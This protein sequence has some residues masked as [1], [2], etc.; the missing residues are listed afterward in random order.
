M[1]GVKPGDAHDSALLQGGFYWAAGYAC[2]PDKQ[3]T[4]QG[5]GSVGVGQSA[6]ALLAI[7]RAQTCA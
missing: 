4:E 5:T 6:G 1:P 7:S 3:G 2:W